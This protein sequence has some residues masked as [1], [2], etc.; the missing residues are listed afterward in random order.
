MNRNINNAGRRG[1]KGARSVSRRTA[2]GFEERRVSDTGLAVLTG[3]LLDE[4]LVRVGDPRLRTRL[5]RAAHESASIAWATPYPLLTVPELFAEKRRE[6]CRQHV[7]QNSILR[8]E[9]G[10]LSLAE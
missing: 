6:A 10:A 8:G 9:R 5:R 3:R 4:Q 1:T 2:I 7:R